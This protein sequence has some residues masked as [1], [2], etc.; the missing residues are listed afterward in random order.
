MSTCNRQLKVEAIEMLARA[1][2]VEAEAEQK[3]QE[4]LLNEDMMEKAASGL[5]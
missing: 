1:R 3:L 4:I 5:E 2:A